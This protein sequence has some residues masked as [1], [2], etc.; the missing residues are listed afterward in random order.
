MNIKNIIIVSFG[1]LFVSCYNESNNMLKNLE[2]NNPWDKD[3]KEIILTPQQLENR[4]CELAKTI[5]KDLASYNS[6]YHNSKL[7]IVIGVLT[8]AAF[9]TTDLSREINVPHEIKFIKASS[10][11]SGTESSGEVK[12]Y[13]LDLTPKDIKDRIVIIVEDI[14]DTGYSLHS[15]LTFL[16]KM[17]PEEI[18]VCCLLSKP[19]RRKVKINVDYL[20]FKVEDKF[21]IGYGLDFDGKYRCLKYVGVLKPEIFKSKL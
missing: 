10:Y 14:I 7:P 9:F 4:V 3:V 18:K 13:D 6:N 19:A 15:I 17:E 5:S 16:K 8:G 12:I 20:G 21:V 2:V 1:W 11:G